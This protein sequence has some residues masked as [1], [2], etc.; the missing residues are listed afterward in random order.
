LGTPKTPPSR[1]Y[2]AHKAAF[3]EEIITRAEEFIPGL[4]AHIEVEEAASPLTFERYTNNWRGS[5][6]GWNWDPEYA[7][8][9][10]FAQDLP[11]KNLSTVGHY[12]F[13]PGG[14]PTAMITAWYIA[15]EI[16]K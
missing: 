11:I 3:V 10:D 13:N 14:V 1:P 15:Q 4:R 2:L 7:P 6:A 5:T 16:L 12:I 9:F 8:R